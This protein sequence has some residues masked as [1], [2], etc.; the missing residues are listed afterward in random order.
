M[1]GREYRR[2]IHHFRAEIAQFH[3]FHESEMFDSVRVADDFR[4]RGHEPVDISPNLKRIGIESRCKNRCRI[5]RSS[6]AEVSDI[7][8]FH[9]RTYETWDYRNMG[10]ISECLEYQTVGLRKIHYMLP[11][12]RSCPDEFPRIVED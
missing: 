12:I 9:V 2:R 4:I 1:V 5:I 3:R 8:A 11:E 7:P 10:Q 6:P